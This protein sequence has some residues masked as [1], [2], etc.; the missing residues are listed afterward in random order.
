MPEE[1]WFDS[2]KSNRFIISPVQLELRCVAHP[3]FYLM[4]IGYFFRLGAKRPGG[5]ADLSPPARAQV[6]NGSSCICTISTTIRL[7]V[8][9]RDTFG[10]SYAVL[11]FLSRIA[12]RCNRLHNVFLSRPIR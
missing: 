9:H 4:S 12:L 1:L 3:A 11:I 8:V 7:H 2:Q 5:E 6:K 10:L